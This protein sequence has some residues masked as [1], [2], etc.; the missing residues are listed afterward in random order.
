MAPEG[1]AMAHVTRSHPLLKLAALI[2]IVGGAAVVVRMTSLGAYLD[3]ETM[4]E[5]LTGLRSSVWAPVVYV[6]VY[7]AATA[8]ALPGSILTIVGG[9]VFG[10]GW[11]VLLGSTLA[12][13]FIQFYMFREPGE[14]VGWT[15]P[16]LDLGLALFLVMLAVFLSVQLV[17]MSSREGNGR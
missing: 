3:R 6:V 15:L 7:A 1:G 11:G 10:F 14:G 13:V 16:F 2:L 9:A 5:T 17:G 8:L 12:F 4:L